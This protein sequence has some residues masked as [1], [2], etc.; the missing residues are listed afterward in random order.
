MATEFQRLMPSIAQQA[1]EDTSQPQWETVSEERAKDSL[2]R[3]YQEW[4]ICR[5]TMV[6]GMLLQ[7]PWATYRIVRT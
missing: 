7:T 4:T 3:Y 2:L 1:G 6:Q 5:M